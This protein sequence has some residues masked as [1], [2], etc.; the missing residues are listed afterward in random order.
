MTTTIEDIENKFSYVPHFYKRKSRIENQV[1][2]QQERN[3]FIKNILQSD[4]ILPK[5]T[6]SIYEDNR[7][8]FINFMDCLNLKRYQTKIEGL[9][10]SLFTTNG[11]FN[12]NNEE[13][14]YSK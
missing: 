2:I 8:K 6:P 4:N 13:D 11:N 12:I 7:N 9:D 14:L 3:L 10:S 1:K 5:C